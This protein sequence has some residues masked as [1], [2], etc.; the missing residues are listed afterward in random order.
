MVEIVLPDDKL[1][2]EDDSFDIQLLYTMLEDIRSRVVRI[3]SILVNEY[4]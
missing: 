4:E 2:I 1:N 3:E